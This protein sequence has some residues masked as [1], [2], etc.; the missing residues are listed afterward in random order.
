[1]KT[2]LNRLTAETFFK[3][4]DYREYSDE[5]LAYMAGCS[6]KEIMNWRL[7]YGLFRPK[8]GE[9]SLRANITFFD[10]DNT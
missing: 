5:K 6:I 4:F 2:D 1:M 3:M 9:P 8:E 10:K 7:E